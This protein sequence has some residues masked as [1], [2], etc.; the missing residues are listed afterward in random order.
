MEGFWLENRL[1][2]FDYIVSLIIILLITA[3]VASFF[4]GVKYGADEMETKYLAMIN[5]D[6]MPDRSKD[7]YHQQHIVSYYYTVFQPMID[8]EKNWFKLYNSLIYNDSASNRSEQIKALT[9]TINEELKSIE[10][11]EMPASSSLLV[12]SQ[13]NALKSLTLFKEV[14]ESL[15]NM[16]NS[17]EQNKWLSKVQEDGNYLQARNFALLSRQQ[18]YTAIVEWNKTINSQIEGLPLLG[19]KSVTIDEW[20][21]LNLNLKNQLVSQILNTAK[22]YTQA[23]PQDFV[24]RIDEMIRSGQAA[25]MNLDTISEIIKTLSATRAVNKGDF[26][27]LQDKYYAEEFV[28]AIPIYTN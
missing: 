17:T 5:K 25:D 12:D 27:L 11:I 13:Q 21:T 18:Y 8:F 14:A 9:S 1:S 22:N 3:N 28:P 20:K 10:A 4:F 26:S 15:Q 16:R 23:M 7:S 6:K 19:K 2:K 24:G